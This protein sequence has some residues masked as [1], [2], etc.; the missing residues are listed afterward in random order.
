M[1]I[2]IPLIVLTGG[3]WNGNYRPDAGKVVVRVLIATEW[4]KGYC[5]M[6]PAVGA[7]TGFAIYEPREDRSRA[8]WSHNEWD[9][10]PCEG[11][12]EA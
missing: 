8:F 5:G 4:Q 9:D 7:K 12:Y 2:R 1:T 6:R 11:T 3:P 10:S